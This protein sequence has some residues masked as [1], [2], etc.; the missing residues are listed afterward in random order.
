MY[1][2]IN[3]RQKIVKIAIQY[4]NFDQDFQPKI[5]LHKQL[6][7]SPTEQVS[8]ENHAILWR[9]VGGEQLAFQEV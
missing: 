9:C 5:I 7:Q 6:T 3:D 1:L 2:T 8:L 4:A